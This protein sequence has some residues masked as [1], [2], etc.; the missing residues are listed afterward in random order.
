MK[1]NGVEKGKREV[2]PCT[3]PDI[4][5]SREINRCEEELYAVSSRLAEEREMP[6]ALYRDSY[7]RAAIERIRG[8]FSASMDAKRT[9]A[10]RVMEHLK[11]KG[12]IKS[13]SSAE[14]QDRHDLE[15]VMGDGRI[16]VVELKGC[17]DGNNTTI[18]ERPPH[19]DEFV[20]WSICANMGGDPRHNVWSGIHTRLSAEIIHRPVVV[21]GLIVWDWLCGSARRCPKLEEDETSTI[22]LTDIS[23]PPPCLYA[24]PANYPSPRHTRHVRPDPLD[25][26]R[27]AGLLKAF[28]DAFGCDDDDISYVEFEVKLDAR[29]GHLKRKT[30]VRRKGRIVAESNFTQIKRS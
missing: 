26:A 13:Y 22:D 30:V 23:L 28:R 1:K 5:Q 14:S 11:Q 25:S 17:L 6:E 15:I 12:F 19:A 2:I 24:F 18:F 10:S 3:E 16:V 8:K 20:I 7:F 9:F 27:N 21:D 4:S 29:T